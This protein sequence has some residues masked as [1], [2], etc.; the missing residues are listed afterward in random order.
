MRFLMKAGAGLS[1]ALLSACVLSACGAAPAA[2]SGSPSP[3]AS[4]AATKP[5]CDLA[6]G[7]LV[8]AQLGVAVGDPEVTTTTLVT[9]CLYPAGSNPAGVIIRFQIREDHAGFL[10]G[11][12]GFSSSAD[13]SGVGDEAYSNVL[14][15]ITTLVARKGT[16]EILITAHAGLPAERSL[17]LILLAKV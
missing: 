5:G 14:A 1:L 9:T 13:V 2:T 4:A 3:A 8:T 15:S 7:S 11:R 17:M 10:V 12:A 6:P 16:V